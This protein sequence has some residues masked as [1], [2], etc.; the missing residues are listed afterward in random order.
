M[1]LK[2]NQILTKV[3]LFGLLGG[4]FGCA[5]YPKSNFDESV[6]RVESKAPSKITQSVLPAVVIRYPSTASSE[7]KEDL[8]NKLNTAVLSGQCS[9]GI[10]NCPYAN[11]RNGKDVLDETLLK[12]A[13]HSSELYNLL[14]QRDPSIQI[15]MQAGV[16]SR[17]NDGQIDL[18]FPAG[19]I[20]GLM[21]VDFVSYVDPYTN[22]TIPGDV[23]LTTFGPYFM[24]IFSLHTEHKGA[25]KTAG[26]I[27]GFREL[28]PLTGRSY[29]YGGPRANFW[30]YAGKA[31]TDEFKGR[32]SPFTDNLI[33]T[34][35]PREQGKYLEMHL[36]MINISDDRYSEKLDSKIAL[37]PI[38]N[39][40]L[41]SLST[42]DSNAVQ[43]KILVEKIAIFDLDLA[44]RYASQQVSGNDSSNVELVKELI[45]VESEAFE[46]FSIVMAK[47]LTEGQVGDAFRKK[48]MDEWE[49]TK[50][51]G[52]AFAKMILTSMATGAVSGMG[53]GNNIALSA[54]LA[55]QAGQNF[56]QE[57]AD[58]S[59]AF[60]D[61]QSLVTQKAYEATVSLNNKQTQLTYSSLAQLREELKG[62]YQE[63]KI[64]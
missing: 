18:I 62:I 22:F 7:V 55:V 2:L 40:I 32:K 53:G 13:F 3:F 21:Y 56:N 39:I 8:I 61:P 35:V 23:I 58:K 28:P 11:L 26:A 60:F 37:N 59:Q 41:D 14:K 5:Y 19:R 15:V 43:N 47:A 57:Q 52:L 25:P 30:N 33:T 54:Q 64:K 4:F 51:H 42:I 31:D 45:K 46:K 20:E 50:G 27:A 24:P 10:P 29:E 48:R 34:K 44:K 36:A 38:V 9:S 1:V 12:S 16:L 17:T 6:Y 49:F 63:Q